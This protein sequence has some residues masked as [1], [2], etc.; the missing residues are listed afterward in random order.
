M[1]Q[2]VTII[3]GG[4]S[5]IGFET[6]KALLQKNHRVLIASRN[7][8]RG[9]NAISALQPFGKVEFK[10]LDLADPASIRSFADHVNKEYTAIHCL[11]NN[12]G[13]MIPPLT[14]TVEGFELQF[15]IN[16]LGHFALTGLL[17]PQLMEANRARIVT[18]SSI[19]AIKGFIDFT[20]LDGKN[21]YK[22]MVFYRQSKFANLLFSKKL[23]QNLRSANS[24]T[25]AVTAHPGLAYSNLLSRGSGKEANLLIRK[26]L[27]RLIQSSANGACSPIYAATDP[28]LEGGEWIG[29]SGH[30]SWYGAPVVS[31][32]GDQLYDEQ[33]ADKLWQ[34]SQEVTGV[35]YSF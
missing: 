10:L 8:A 4:T 7:E 30:R 12:A 1:N 23:Q 16:H 34:F 18:I 35:T 3:T 19:A 31:T 29:P 6:A 33:T 22:P 28:L 24:S 27:P 21:G 5:G 25:I 2:N 17:L 32:L 9:K 26:L 20:N 14:H 15:G 13:V 11:I